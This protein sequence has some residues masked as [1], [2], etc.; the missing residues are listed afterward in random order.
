VLRE[1]LAPYFAYWGKVVEGLMMGWE[2][3]HE[4]RSK[5]IRVTIGHAISFSTWRSLIREQGLRLCRGFY[6][7]RFLKN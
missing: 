4:Q 2:G 1:V 5:Q 6:Q 7:S 3:Q